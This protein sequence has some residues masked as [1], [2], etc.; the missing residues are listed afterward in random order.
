[1]PFTEQEIRV[2]EEKNPPAI[3]FVPLSV[4]QI[5]AE[6]KLKKECNNVEELLQEKNEIEKRIKRWLKSNPGKKN[7]KIYFRAKFI[8]QILGQSFGISN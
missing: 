2:Q 5:L 1:M 3:L 4:Q 8:G 6:I 7:K